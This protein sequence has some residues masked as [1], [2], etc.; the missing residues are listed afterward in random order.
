MDLL[1]WNS[2]AGDLESAIRV[3]NNYRNVLL[4]GKRFPCTESYSILLGLYVHK[5]KNVE[6]V[7]FFKRLIDE[8]VNPNPITLTIVIHHFV[9][10]G[11]LDAVKEVFELLPLMRMKRTLKQY[12][13]LVEG[14]SFAKRFDIVKI[15][16]EEMHW[17]IFRMRR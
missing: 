2:I 6:A 15:L 16:V 10:L 7:E 4:G 1:R 8:G 14:F 3:R 5:G 17:I 13:I 11:K 9:R 12:S